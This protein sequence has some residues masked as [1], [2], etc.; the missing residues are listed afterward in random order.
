M[1]NATATLIPTTTFGGNVGNYVNTLDSFNSNAALGDGYFGSN[2]G[3]HSASYSV[4]NF[5][6]NIILQGTLVKTP[7]EADWFN[8]SDTNYVGTANVGILTTSSNFIGNFVWVRANV[9]VF[10][11]GTINKVLFNRS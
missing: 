5:L 4:T 10:S 6:G 1:S 3:L 11:Q 2:D 7:S 8:I 9:T